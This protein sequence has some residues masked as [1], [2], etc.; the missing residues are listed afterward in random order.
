M[1]MTFTKGVMIACGTAGAILA[2]VSIVG[3]VMD[4]SLTDPD[5]SQSPLAPLTVILP[6]VAVT[7]EDEVRLM[8]VR[9]TVSGPRERDILCSQVRRLQTAVTREFAALG[10]KGS[11]TGDLDRALQR[12]FD[13]VAG[14]NVIERVDVTMT[15]QGGTVPAGNCPPAGT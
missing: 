1:E 9:L 13:S 7:L 10:A 8:S 5:G 15:P 12:R 6:P 3:Q 4:V 11:R 14:E 2:T